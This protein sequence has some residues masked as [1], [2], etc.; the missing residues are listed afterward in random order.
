MKKL[1]PAINRRQIVA[2]TIL[3][4]LNSD[5][6]YAQT[7]VYVSSGTGFFINR[8]GY[9][10]TNLHV[11]SQCQRIVVQSARLGPYFARVIG[12]NITNDLALLKVDAAGLEPPSL[13]TH[14][15]P[16]STNEQ[17]MIIGYPGDSYK[18]LQSVARNAVVTHP[19]GPNAEDG[20]FQVSDLI[21]QG[22]SGGPLLDASGNVLGVI[23]AR[24]VTY[25]YQVDNP[26]D[27]TT[28]RSGVVIALSAL[29]DFLNEYQISYTESDANSNLG[30]DRLVDL[31]GRF[32]VNVRCE[33]ETELR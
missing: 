21:E 23:V 33:T 9:L 25:R 19:K 20:W 8:S 32:V 4:L 28:T 7:K 13:R 2:V 14:A 16:V 24:A 11:V 1:S 12:R 22:N 18:T 26:H 10:V 17:V 30:A 29:K 15:R 5:L 31:A 6:V 3:F 27:G